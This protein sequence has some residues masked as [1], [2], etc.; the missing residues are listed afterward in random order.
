MAEV[1][2]VDLRLLAGQAAQAQID[3]SPKDV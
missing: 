2:P 3:S 1:S